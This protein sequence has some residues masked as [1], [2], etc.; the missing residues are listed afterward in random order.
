VKRFLATVLGVIIFLGAIALPVIRSVNDFPGGHPGSQLAFEVSLGESGTS[1]ADHLVSSGVIKSP[2]EFLRQFAADPVVRSISPG[3]HLIQT[4]IPSKTAIAQLL[5]PKRIQGLINLREGSTYRDL[6]RQMRNS[7]QFD[8]SVVLPRTLVPTIANP[9]S[10]F[11][12]QL[13]PA[14]YPFAA[15]TTFPQALAVMSQ[16]FG[17]Q[18]APLHLAHGVSGYSAYQNLIIASLV[19]IEG[20]PKDYGRVAQVIFNRLKIGMAL[21]LNSTVQYALGNQGSIALS[22]KATEV[23]SPY[24]TY[25]RAGLP[26]TP[27]AFPSVAAIR[28]TLSPTAGQWLYFIT[29][30][31]RDTRF[32]SNFSEFSNWVTLFN[33]NVAKGLFK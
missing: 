21:Q 4:H 25:R 30:A 32:T 22:R 13:A 27:I 6:L 18:I 2:S 24:N 23:N 8:M 20:D 10:S 19:Q 5:D 11:E 26:P 1:I 15:H 31:P 9:T 17:E 16:K 12:G 14:L 3:R 29:V 28:A 7:G 33:S